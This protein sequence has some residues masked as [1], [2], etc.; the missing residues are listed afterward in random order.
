MLVRNKLETVGYRVVL[1]NAKGNDLD[2]R[3]DSN[4]RIAIN[5]KRVYNSSLYMA[6]LING[7]NI[8]L[9]MKVCA[10]SASVCA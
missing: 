6:L 7:I 9:L 3:E 1:L 10:R 2:N 5:S 4:K 8:N